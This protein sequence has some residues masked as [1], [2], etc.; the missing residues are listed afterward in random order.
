MRQSLRSRWFSGQGARRAAVQPAVVSSC[1]KLEDRKLMSVS[2]A[3][4]DGIAPS[5]FDATGTFTGTLRLRRAD[6]Q[7]RRNYTMTLEVN[8][9]SQA[10]DV[11]GRVDIAEI[12]DSTYDDG[13]FS[14]A[15]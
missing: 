13:D 7:G 9:Q 3:A 4:E 10:G 2:A 5:E 15:P 1:E 6:D 8:S 11:D 12:G 14:P